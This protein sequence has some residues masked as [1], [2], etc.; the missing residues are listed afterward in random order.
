V[1]LSARR[2][3]GGGKEAMGWVP[4]DHGATIGQRGSENG[5]IVRDEEHELG[6]RVTL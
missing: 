2:S 3:F 1:A 4:L 6:A 5:I